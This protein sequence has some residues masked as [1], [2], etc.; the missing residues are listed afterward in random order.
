MYSF[1]CTESILENINIEKK[2]R[3]L[4]KNVFGYYFLQQKNQ[5]K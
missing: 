4:V 2:I 1:R 3:K 5:T